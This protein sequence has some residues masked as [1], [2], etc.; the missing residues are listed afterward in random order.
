MEAIP[1]AAIPEAV[2]STEVII[3]ANIYNT[4]YFN[5]CPGGSKRIVKWPLTFSVPYGAVWI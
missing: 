1:E 5:P 3:I 2:S 4:E